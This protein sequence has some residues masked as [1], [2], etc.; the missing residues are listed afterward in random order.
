MSKLKQKKDQGKN[1]KFF[2]CALIGVIFIGILVMLQLKFTEYMQFSNPGLAIHSGTVGKYLNINPNEQEPE[3][4][5]AMHSFKAAD[6]LYKHNSN[7]FFGDKKRVQMDVNFPVYLNH[8]AS[9]QMVNDS[10]VLLD[11]NYEKT[12]TYKGLIINEGSA[13][14]PSGTQADAGNYIFLELKNGYY[15]NLT[16]V[17]YNKSTDDKVINEH[18]IIN[19]QKDFFAFYKIENDELIYNYC[20][21]IEND[22]PITVNDE[23]YTYEEFLILIGAYKPSSGMD[24]EKPTDE[25]PTTEY[26]AETVE[27]TAPMEN[28]TTE[29]E[30]EIPTEEETTEEETTEEETTEAPTEEVTTDDMTEGNPDEQPSEEEETQKSPGVRPDE[31][32]PDKYPTEPGEG[33][34]KV[35]VVPEYVKPIVNVGEFVEG[36]YRVSTVLEII[37]PA[38]RIDK[39][40]QVQ[41]EVYEVGP[42]NRESLVMRCFSGK[43]GPLVIGD[44]IIEPSTKYHIVYYF[45]YYNEYD[46]KVVEQLGDT[47]VT[48]KGRDTLGTIYLTHEPGV[49]YSNRIEIANVGYGEGTDEEAVYGINLAAGITISIS[50]NGEDVSSIRLNSTQIRRFKSGIN[51]VLTSLSNLSARTTYQ[52]RFYVEDYFGNVLKIANETGEITT[53]RNMPNASMTLVENNIGDAQ[54]VLSIE[55]VDASAVIEDGTDNGIYIVITDSSKGIE[56]PEELDS[57][58]WYYKLQPG[59]YTYSPEEGLKVDR[60]S[61]SSIDCLRL[62]K[63]YY[64]I[65]YCDYDLDNGQGVQHFSE[66]G[67]LGFTSASLAVLGKVYLESEVTEIT[68][69]SVTID[70]KLNKEL[71]N[72]ML[73][74]LLEECK[75]T[76]KEKADDTVVTEFGFDRDDKI[77]DTTFT[78]EVFQNG[79]TITC[80]IENLDS[81]TDYYVEPSV[82]AYYLDYEEDIMISMSKLTFKT[83]RKPATVEIS[84]LLC[85]AGTLE[86]DVYIRDED[87][88]ITGNFG[89]RIVLNL[90]TEDGDFI[91]ALRVSKNELHTI[92]FTQLDVSKNYVLRFIAIE[93]NEGYTNATLQSNVVLKSLDVSTMLEVSGNIKLQHIDEIYNN[94]S[95]YAAYTKSNIKTG[96]AGDLALIN[97]RFYVRIEKD[98]T[99][100]SDTEYILE[101]RHL[102]DGIYV[103]N[104]KDNV[105]IGQHTYKYTLY[106]VAESRSLVLDTLEFTTESTVKGFSTAYELIKHMQNDPEGKYV[107][108]N[109][110]VL[111]STDN[112][113]YPFEE[114]PEDRGDSVLGARVVTT[115]DGILDFQ[116]YTL[117]HHYEAGSSQQFVQNFGSNAKLYDVV[118]DV[119]FD[120]DTQVYDAGVLCY[121]NFG[122]ISDIIINYRGGSITSNSYCGLI[123]RY[124]ASCG[125]IER[126]VVNN[127]PDPDRQ[128]FSGYRHAALLISSNDGIIRDGY[129]AGEDIYLTDASVPYARYCGGI[130]GQSNAIGQLSNL[131]SL[132]NFLQSE[133]GNTGYSY[134]YYYGA[135]AGYVAGYFH[136]VY[137]VGESTPAEY[138][139]NTAIDVLS[140]E[141]GVQLC[142]TFGHVVNGRYGDLYYWFDMHTS[143]SDSQTYKTTYA[144]MIQLDTLYNKTWQTA[145]LGDQFE[146]EYVE[147]GYFPKVIMSEEMPFQNNIELPERVETTDLGISMASVEKYHNNDDGEDSAD[148]KIVFLNKKNFTITGVTIDGVTVQL[149]VDSATSQDGYTTIKGKVTNPEKFSSSYNISEITY[150]R[151]N[152]TQRL[153]VKYDMSMEFFRHVSSADDWYNYV[154]RNAANKVVEN[155]RLTKDIDFKDVAEGKIR[156]TSQFD[157]KIDG[158]GKALK[159][160]DLQKDFKFTNN[161]KIWNLFSAVVGPEAEIYN[162]KIKNYKGGGSYTKNG[163][164]YVARY[165]SVFYNVSGVIRD[166]HMKDV[167]IVAYDRMGVYAATMNNGSEIKDCSVTGANLI[168]EQPTGVD[169]TIVLGG[170]AGY[171]SYTRISNSYVTDLNVVA[172]YMKGSMG[173]GGIV[174][175]S[176]NSIID[177]VYVTGDIETRATNVGGIVGQYVTTSVSIVCIEDVVSKVNIRSYTDTVGGL[178]GLLNIPVD[179]INPNN[180]TSGIASGIAFGDVYAYNPDST[181]V[182]RTVGQV[183]AG[184][185]MFH[186]CDTQLLNGQIGIALTDNEAIC[187]EEIISVKDIK[188]DTNNIYV[189]RIKLGDRFRYSSEG[190]IPKLLYSG[191]EE[192]LPNQEENILIED[193]NETGI[194]ITNVNINPN[195]RIITLRILNPNHYLLTGL[196]I[197]NLNVS[198]VKYANGGYVE[199]GIEEAVDYTGDVTMVLLQYKTNQNYYQDSYVLDEISFYDEKESCYS[200]ITVSEAK[201]SNKI[202]TASVFARVGLTLYREINSVTQWSLIPTYPEYENYRITQ[203]LDFE[204]FSTYATEVNIGRLDGNGYTFRNINLTNKNFIGQINSALVDINFENVTINS[205]VTTNVGLVEVC[206][207]KVSDCNFKDVTV[208]HTY[209]STGTLS[210][211]GLISRQNGG[212]IENVNL[213][214]VTVKIAAGKANY[215]GGLIG[216]YYGVGK[217][218]NVNAIDV[219]VKGVTYVG[220]LIGCTHISDVT[221][222]TI[223]RTNVVGTGSYV[224]ILTGRIGENTNSQAFTVANVHIKGNPVISDGVIIGSD[225]SVVGKGEVGAIAGRSY[226]S[227]CRDSGGRYTDV[228]NVVDGVHVKG[229]ANNIGGAYG[230]NYNHGYNINVS[231]TL[232]EA[233]ASKKCTAVGGITGYSVYGG[234]YLTGKNNRI[235]TKNFSNVGGIYG[236][237]ERSTV[238]YN[239]CEN[240]TIEALSTLTTRGENV[241]GAIGYSSYSSHNFYGVV[242]SKILASTMNNVGGVIGKLG[243][244]LTTNYTL[245]QSYCIAEKDSSKVATEEAAVAKPEYTIEGHANVGGIVGALE[246]SNITYSYS[247]MNVVSAGGIEAVAGGLTGYYD[248]SY[249]Q[250][251]GSSI[252]T[253]SNAKLQYNYFAGTVSAP[254][255]FAGGAFGVSGLYRDYNATGGRVAG[256]SGKVNEASGNLTLRNL[257]FAYRVDGGKAGAFAGDEGITFTG[258]SNRIFDGVMVN[259]IAV[260]RLTDNTGKYLYNYWSWNNKD[261]WN[262]PNKDNEILIFKTT[263][264]EE[265]SASTSGTKASNFYSEICWGAR[266][267]GSKL[268]RNTYWRISL[269]GRVDANERDGSCVGNYLPQVRGS[270]AE[271]SAYNKDYVIIHQEKVGRLNIPRHTSFVRSNN[272]ISVDNSVIVQ[273]SGDKNNDTYAVLYVSDVDK[274]NLEFS[275]DMI[276]TKYYILTTESGKVIDEGVVSHRVYTFTYP[277]NEN[278][279][280]TYGAEDT[281]MKSD[282]YTKEK[283]N[284]NIMV[285]GEYY[286]YF[287][288]NGIVYGNA[289][290]S[291]SVSGKFVNMMNGK[292]LDADGY[293]WKLN[294]GVMEKTSEV[295]DDIKSV[296]EQVPLFTGNYN[297]KVVKAYAKCSEIITDGTAIFRDAQLVVSNNKL[298]TVDGNLLNQKDGVL[299][300]NKNGSDYLT[301]LGNDGIMVDMLNEDVNIPDDEKVNFKNKAIVAMTNTVNSKV[302]FVIVK[303]ANGGIFGYNYMSG[304]VLFDKRVKEQVS[305]MDYAGEYYSNNDVSMYAEISN[306]YKQNLNLSNKLEKPADLDAMLGNSIPVIPGIDSETATETEPDTP[307]TEQNKE[308]IPVGN[309]ETEAPTESDTI[310]NEAVDNHQFMAVYNVKTET[311]T[312]V[313][314]D[315]YLTNSEYKSE[316]ERLGI[317]NIAEVIKGKPANAESHKDEHTRRGIWIYVIAAVLLAGGLITSVPVMR[318]NIKNRRR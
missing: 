151:N 16:P 217:V 125:V 281:G 178:V 25:E 222:V 257:I 94:N 304:E 48:T 122:T 173:V 236:T 231:N 29:E 157:A 114:N 74:G 205:N 259:G 182:S 243:V 283:I 78:Y 228:Y 159:N 143:Q 10:A 140:N 256:V 237:K 300:Y 37:D 96:G 55:D 230:Y 4:N 67:K 234:G 240:T 72:E 76:I 175:Y 219:N 293:I 168:Y 158:N 123:G 8:G 250:V 206:N 268:L 198:F 154:V 64:A 83:M 239:Q 212:T 249:R 318:K 221:D 203:D 56:S 261:N 110:I 200:G 165:G 241:G 91:K 126:F 317:D 162:L 61:L 192:L 188:E 252:K 184:K 105:D 133:R 255:G 204:L 190:Y 62:N 176:T 139:N 129:A 314:I 49:S 220:G 75:F 232:V 179:I 58:V 233:T 167:D 201:N 12:E 316:N 119:Y 18:S 50:H 282:T 104:F 98:G 95:Q 185:L 211:I 84:N 202:K 77:N 189:N 27:P 147:T 38:K 301:I 278:L 210:E 14:N 51:Q 22:M 111:Y 196:K 117:E 181:Y 302:P 172:N 149:D 34:D 155:V 195:N 107:A 68:S 224:G 7:L 246:G 101:D 254:R 160:I 69:S 66:I 267:S 113:R 208:N 312:I 284:R 39:T 287:D 295:T 266:V 285:Y 92:T 305:I 86:F 170:I 59:E 127:V 148:I 103:N 164:T 1:N 116:G 273:S 138:K 11:E 191:K 227:S 213:E 70:Y 288:A 99:V 306:T 47:Y 280:L 265:P 166:V 171:I 13:Y 93:Y 315:E 193:I 41:F 153:E 180:Q 194:E 52:Y 60:L 275:A 32:R 161:S 100:V 57:A 3:K 42:K 226:V 73:A 30:T 53:S 19:F 247:N 223:E 79:D 54:I 244:D 112:Y 271:K 81:M 97:N 276:G 145:I 89:D 71:T 136:N 120:R 263:D 118:Y 279:V 15:M 248:N 207:G 152:R 235:V 186:A 258:R 137:S 20:V 174:G 294:D 311:Y 46:E 270:A 313:M 169:S 23:E 253:Y 264:I 144:D 163:K 309:P 251:A 262:K 85:A 63:N 197:E 21:D 82:K 80:K 308:S 298:W 90:Y 183:A 216:Y 274:I 142:P 35:P 45:T 31:M 229:E 245:S 289:T 297:G 43:T 218:H 296:E 88:A 108:V 214:R 269:D 238:K 44:G 132:V 65:A 36:V 2:V 187:T 146:T 199:C 303:Y 292:A 33:D 277:F 209:K 310:I 131:Y 102:I 134:S 6:F 9:L 299:V 225:T 121:R 215:V 156:V 115:F 291:K 28:E 307:G 5:V 40:K 26:E 150:L 135:V 109:D 124:N 290:K 24:D 17:M 130:V 242:N 260:D 286:Y 87:E 128:P 272:T 106:I 177:S 141:Y